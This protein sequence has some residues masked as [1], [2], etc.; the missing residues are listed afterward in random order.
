MGAALNGYRDLIAMS[1]RDESNCY[2][3]EFPA[4]VFY[5]FTFFYDGWDQEY[6]AMHRRVLKRY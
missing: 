1:F 4:T 6:N 2:F 5:D 3:Y